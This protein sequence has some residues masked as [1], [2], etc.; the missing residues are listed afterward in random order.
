MLKIQKITPCLWFEGNAEEAVNFYISIF[1]QSRVLDITRYGDGAPLPKGTPLVITF[2]LEGQSFMVL[3]AGP[4]DKFNDA[5][6]LHVLCDTQ[7]EIDRLWQ[8]LPSGGGHPVQCGWLKDKYGVS[9]QIV[10][11]MLPDLLRSDDA[12]KSA[13][14]M[15]ALM[16]MVKLDIKQLQAAYDG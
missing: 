3:N 16:K 13:R 4:H 5:I 2:E 7:E 6:S 10:P 9:W 12:E 8:H 15:Q 11:S 14:V 1:A